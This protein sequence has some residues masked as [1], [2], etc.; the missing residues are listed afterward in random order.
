M[1]CTTKGTV[2][3]IME[4]NKMDKERKEAVRLLES[5]VSLWQD[6]HRKEVEIR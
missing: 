5:L 6:F 2:F 4:S 1:K 3:A